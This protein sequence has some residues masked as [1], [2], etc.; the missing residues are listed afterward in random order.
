MVFALPLSGVRLAGQRAVVDSYREFMDRVTLTRYRE[1]TP[2]VDVWGDTAIASFRWEMDWL[3]G[4]VSN[5]EAGADIFVFCRRGAT[6]W[7]AVWRTM[8]FE[9]SRASTA[10][11]AA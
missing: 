8:M 4:N 9:P 7:R 10:A 2:S 6:Q 11:P 3:A 1:D 5:C